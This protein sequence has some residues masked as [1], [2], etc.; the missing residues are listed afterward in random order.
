MKVGIPVAEYCG[1]ESLVYGHFGSAPAFVLVDSETMAVE[2]LGNQDQAHVHG[3]CRPMKAL[4]GTR[5]DAVVVGGIGAGALLGLRQAGI[6]V[7]QS[8]GKTVAEVVALLKTGDLK[9]VAWENAC[10]GHGDSG[11]HHSHD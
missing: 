5:P 11:C 3:Q 2:L 10:A 8:A 4:A 6:K 9:E 1:L 7:Y